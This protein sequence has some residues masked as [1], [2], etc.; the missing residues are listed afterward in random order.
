M[1]K[2]DVFVWA[3]DFEDFTGEGLLARCFV[4][5]YFAKNIKLKKAN[6]YLLACPYV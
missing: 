2:F 3:S 1:K 6:D 4:K 5:K